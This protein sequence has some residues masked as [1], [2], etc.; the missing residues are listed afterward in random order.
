MV[1]AALSGGAS[2][3]QYRNKMADADLRIRQARVLLKL[4]RQHGAALIINDHA[5]LCLELDADGVHLGGDDG[6]AA[7]IRAQ[8]GPERIL[9]VSCYNRFE[10]ALTAQAQGADYVA[11]GAC[12]DS[13]TKPVAVHAPLELFRRAQSEL[14]IPVVA[15]GGIT[16]ANAQ[17]ALDIGA[18]AIAVIGELFFANDITQTARQFS[19]LFNH[20]DYH[21]LTQ[22]AVI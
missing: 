9:G 22:P 6:D 8:L 16:L 14:Q 11:F 4:C 20:A 10:L 13:A 5:A 18:N 21:D 3:I 12:F 17:L 2:L 15:I 19:N 1:D 7:A